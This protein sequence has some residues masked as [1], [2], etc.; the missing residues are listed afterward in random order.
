MG[1]GWIGQNYPNPFYIET[2]ISYQLPKTSNVK[3][4]IYIF[5]EQKV[6]IL[7]NERQQ[8][9]YHQIKWDAS[10]FSSGAYYDKLVAGEFQDVKKMILL[11]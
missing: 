2:L 4:S 3:L 7:V 8:A 10:Q 5:L 1:N 6:A 9:G 11:R